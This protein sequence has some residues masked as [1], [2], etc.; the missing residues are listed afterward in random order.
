MTSLPVGVHVNRLA[1][2]WQALWASG[3]FLALVTSAAALQSPASA[4][5]PIT[6]RASVV[7][8]DTIDVAFRR[9]RLR[10]VDAP[11]S[12]Q[13]C[14][15]EAGEEYRCGAAAASALDAFLASSRPITCRPVDRDEYGRTVGDCFREDGASVSEWMVR[16]GW[17]LDWPRY[18]KGAYADE[19]A[20]AK[21][22]RAGMWRG[23]FVEPW[24]ARQRH[25]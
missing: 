25:R 13:T 16:S 24:L 3:G 12:W 20:E 5:E 7:D 22:A 23:V 21:A 19:Q 6:G 17:A 14:R 8:G 9:V 2:W 10:G 1:R 18:S 15:D 4:A 11:E